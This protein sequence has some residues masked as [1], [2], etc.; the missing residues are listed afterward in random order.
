MPESP[1]PSS[2][3]TPPVAGLPPVIPPPP[4]PAAP[5]NPGLRPLV[6]VLLSI[7]LGI[8]LADAVLAFADSSLVLL[9][10]VHGLSGVRAIFGF[11]VFLSSVLI[12]VLMGLTPMIPKRWFL[13]VTLFNPVVLLGLIP[14]LIY[15]YHLAPQLDWLT[16]LL[17][18]L[19]GFAILFWIQAG[20]KWRWPVVSAQQLGTRGFSIWN[21]MGFVLANLFLLAPF[22]LFYLLFCT[23]L[24]LDHFTGGFLKLRPGGLVVEARKYVRH[25][26]K[27]IQLFP[28]AHVGDSGFYQKI[29]QAFPT[30]SLILVEGVSDEKNLLT[31]GISYQRMARALGLAEQKQA[32]KPTQGRVVRADVDVDEFAPSTINLLNLTMLLHAQGPNAQNMSKLL[33]YPVTPQAQNQLFDDILEKR[34]QHL[35][36]EIQK[37]LLQADYIV[38]PW[39]AAHMPGIAAEIEQAGFKLVDTHRYVVVRFGPARAKIAPGPRP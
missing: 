29:T 2:D 31:K 19:V 15:F 38:V 37:R 25:D 12:Y 8:F 16:C 14:G 35:W 32:F 39:G 6:A 20:R 5:A 7:G 24:G 3:Q 33:N 26:G 30:N 34:N 11:F 17:Q 22:L 4:P 21:L 9:F 36:A 23:A 27:T 1:I 28:M 10:N 18:V 13:P